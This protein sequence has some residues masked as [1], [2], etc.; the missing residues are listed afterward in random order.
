MLFIC[1]VE[2][3]DANDKYMQSAQV[4]QYFLDSVKSIWISYEQPPH[5]GGPGSSNGMIKDR[6][7]L[8]GNLNISSLW[9]IR[10]CL[11]VH[12]GNEMLRQAVMNLSRISDAS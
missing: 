6:N 9:V 11:C 10:S 5:Q 12:P 7:S 3:K 8:I 4:N 2:C 1:G